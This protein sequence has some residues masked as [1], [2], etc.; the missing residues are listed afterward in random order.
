MSSLLT[1]GADRIVSMSSS[2]T[3]DADKIVLCHCR[4]HSLWIMTEL[5]HCPPYSPWMLTELSHC[6][7]PLRR[8]FLPSPSRRHWAFSS[9][10]RPKNPDLTS[11]ITLCTVFSSTVASLPLDAAAASGCCRRRRRYCCCCC[12]CCFYQWTSPW[13]PLTISK[14]LRLFAFYLWKQWRGSKMHGLQ[15]T[16]ISTKSPPGSTLVI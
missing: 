14:V 3:L 2:L 10:N 15:F 4:V 9:E 1:L 12:C 6:R 16:M 11:H 7:V 13:S 5:N 8:L